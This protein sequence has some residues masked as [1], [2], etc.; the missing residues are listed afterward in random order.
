M[1]EHYKFELKPLPYSHDALE[2]YI[3][4]ETMH[5]HH[6]KHLQTYVDNLNKTLADY[7]DYQGWSLQELIKKQNQLPD[8]IR[9]AVRN[10]AGGVYNHQLYFDG[11]AKAGE[12]KLSGSL[13]EAIDKCFGTYDEFIAQ[14]KAAAL[15]QFGS[16]WA[17]LVTDKGGNLQIVATP[18]QDTPLTM[19]LCPV[20][21]VDVWEHAYYLKNQNRRPEYFDHWTNV[22]NWDEAQKNYDACRFE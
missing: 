13:A 8:A 14:L 1:K 17:W 2:P 5:F 22:I 10:N 9:T 15:G 21:L 20:L 16:G 6:D 19:E 7:P 3:D 18:N 12:T 11:M 4:K